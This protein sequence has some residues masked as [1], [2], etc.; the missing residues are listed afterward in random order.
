MKLLDVQ[1]ASAPGQSWPVFLTCLSIGSELSFIIASLH[2][3]PNHP[4]TSSVLLPTATR[5][6]GTPSLCLYVC[7]DLPARRLVDVPNSM[8]Y[9]PLHLAA[10]E[11]HEEA[12]RALLQGGA[13][14]RI[15]CQLHVFLSYCM[16]KQFRAAATPLHIAAFRHDLRLCICLLRIQV[17]LALTHLALPGDCCTPASWE[18]CQKGR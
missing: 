6:T 17:R 18:P 4:V 8:G 16:P 9:A 14:P 2:L 15:P 3:H 10:A 7:G 5:S 12:V 11:G 1:P 13:D